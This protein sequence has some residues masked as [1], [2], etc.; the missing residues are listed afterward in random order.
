VFDLCIRDCDLSTTW[1][2]AHDGWKSSR[3]YVKPFRNA[4]VEDFALATNDRLLIVVRERLA[5]VRCR[6]Y[7]Q[8]GE[9]IEVLSAEAFHEECENAAEWP[10]DFV[11]IQIPLD[12]AKGAI[13][14]CAGLWGS[15]PLYLF[16]GNGE[17]RGHWDP[18]EL[19]PYLSSYR[20]IPEL[21]ARFLVRYEFPYSRKTLFPE[22]HRLTERSRGRWQRQVGNRWK[23]TIDYPAAAVHPLCARTLKPEADVIA[24][25]LDIVAA[26]VRRWLDLPAASLSAQLSGGLD[27]AIVAGTAS[28]LSGYSLRTYGIVMPGPAGAQQQERR[29][30]LSEVFGLD[31]QRLDM[32][33][34]L[35]FAPEGTRIAAQRVVPWEEAYFEAFE[36]LLILARKSGATVSLNGTGGDEL[37]SRHWHEMTSDQQARRRQEVLT[38]A[39]DLPPYLSRSACEAIRDT[40]ST[41]DRAPVSPLFTSALD[42]ACA[43]SSLFLRNGIWPIS[44][45]CT[46]EL[47]RFCRSL[48]LPWRDNR[49]IQRELLL[50]MGCSRA[51][52][53]PPATEDF[54][55]TLDLTVREASRPLLERLFRESHLSELGLVDAGRLL[56]AYRE[57]CHGKDNSR[58]AS[59]YSAGILELTLRSV[60]NAGVRS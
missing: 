59:F 29:R 46:P 20:L 17:L 10:L 26:S 51:V 3:S 4:A 37:C 38:D 33:D 16:G 7:P 44:P 2:G 22:I 50:R 19:Y 57:Y 12:P 41:I 5:G 43:V 35:P 6:G 18:A 8:S 14:F 56:S 53:Y 32:L 21:A 24:G 23:L 11:S 27:S 55:P 54:G 1:K 52:A 45:L 30:E 28:R 58:S 36:A 25:F 42:G 49:R 15:A 31:D 9:S 13:E 60:K 39:V 34:H 48:P 40:L 47:V